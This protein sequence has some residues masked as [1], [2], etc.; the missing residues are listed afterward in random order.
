MSGISV[1]HED[2]VSFPL[3]NVAK[4]THVGR[5]EILNMSELNDNPELQKYSSAVLQ[6]MSGVYLPATFAEAILEKLVE[7][8]QISKV[9]ERAFTCS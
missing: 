8:I 5:P 9:S 2:A 7:A 3:L 6:V 4:V 1:S